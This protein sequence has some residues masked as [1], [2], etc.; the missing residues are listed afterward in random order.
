[1]SRKTYRIRL[2][3]DGERSNYRTDGIPTHCCAGGADLFCWEKSSERNGRNPWSGYVSL[4]IV[5]ASLAGY[6][7]DGLKLEG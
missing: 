6:N 4:A 3:I 2:L 1:M 7:P 5:K